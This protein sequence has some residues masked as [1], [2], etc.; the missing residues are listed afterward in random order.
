MSIRSTLH[1][2]GPLRNG[3]R[4]ADTCQITL[5]FRDV[6]IDP[7]IVRSAL[8]TVTMGTVT[9]DEYK[10]GVVDGEARQSDG[11]LTSIVERTAD[12]ELRFSGSRTRFV[13]FVDDWVAS[14][15]EDE[16]VITLDCRDLTAL[17]L[18]QELPVGVR[19]NMGVPIEQGVRE[20]VDR[21]NSTK[22]M[23]VFF[24]TP[25]EFDSGKFDP[26]PR[27]AGPIPQDSMAEVQKARKG[28][29][30]KKKS[31]DKKTNVWDHI[32]TACQKLGLIAYVR[33]F[34]IFISFPRNVYRQVRQAKGM[35]YGE[36]IQGLEVSRKCGRD[37]TTNTYQVN[38]YD[39]DIGRTRW[40][41]HPVEDGEPKSGILG[42]PNSPQPVASRPNKVTPTGKAS[43]T[44]IH[45]TVNGVVD[46][47]VLE[48]IAE[49]A[50]EEVAR[51][52]IEGTFS[53]INT[54]S[55]P[56]AD[57]LELPPDDLM[58]LQSGDPVTLLV[59]SP[60][61][62]AS[63][64]PFQETPKGDGTETNLLQL[65]AQSVAARQ[66][67][68]ERTGISPPTARRL[69]LAQE[70]VGLLTTFRAGVINLSFDTEDGIS[71][72]VG[73]YNFI[74]VRETGESDQESDNSNDLPSVNMTEAIRNI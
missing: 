57:G 28:K 65:Q 15:S 60:E 32:V 36:N 53:T 18:T 31:K 51:Q 16:D 69:A 1:S 38:A 13:G 42:D 45:E 9:A 49:N 70:Q 21:F 7:R 20:L 33:G 54:S 22:R 40:A 25:D 6:P 58:D 64:N 35:M 71:M 63:G 27:E 59:A 73:F 14:F 34:V 5:D 29:K 24:G 12:E 43:E 56:Q 10:R 68:L 17:L 39:P 8:V 72:E 11:M 66:A 62:T 50:W 67:F 30:G 44:V 23:T 52:E 47:A 61:Q 26:V 55:V 41:R 19:L 46:L 2:I 48:R 37:I 74:T 4:D 3:I